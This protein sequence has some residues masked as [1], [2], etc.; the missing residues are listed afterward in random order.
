M[1]NLTKLFANAQKDFI[2][3]KA[4]EQSVEQLY[5]II[6]LLRDRNR[7]PEEEYLLAQL[8]NLVGNQIGAMKVLE[9]GLA[10]ANK[11]EATPLKELLSDIQKQDAWKVKHYRDLRGSRAIK[12]ATQLYWDD[13]SISENSGGDYFEVKISSEIKEIVIANKYLENHELHIGI[14]VS[15]GLQKSVEEDWMH[16]LMT[17]LEW[18]SGIKDEL[19]DF[20]NQSRFDYK[21]G[22]VGKEWFDGLAV[23]NLFIEIAEDETLSTDIVL[24]DYLRNDMGFNLTFQDREMIDLEYDPN[25]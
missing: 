17:H 6:Y 23:M 18:L 2:A 7:K 21:L 1:E 12:P 9:A 16:K 25:L 10:N 19:I 22:K 3:T 5:D 4:S 11:D 24:L 14:F 8:H 13:F 20:Y 15:S